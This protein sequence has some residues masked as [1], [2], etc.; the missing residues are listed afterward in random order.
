[1]ISG[2]NLEAGGGEMIV[3]VS[4]AGHANA[5]T[6]SSN[7]LNGPAGATGLTKS[8][9]GQLVL[10][11]SNSYTGHHVNEGLLTYGGRPPSPAARPPSTAAPP[12]WT[13]TATAARWAS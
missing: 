6:I 7:I 3:Y 8:G 10:S 5:L 4:S 13:S 2:G 11:G 12:C 1:M 9:V